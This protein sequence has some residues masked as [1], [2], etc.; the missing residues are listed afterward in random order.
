LET[1]A[2]PSGNSGEPAGGPRPEYT[3]VQ[4]IIYR[5]EKRRGAPGEEN[6]QRAHLRALVSR[7]SAVGTLIE[8]FLGHF[9]VARASSAPRRT[10][11]FVGRL[12]EM[13]KLL[14]ARRP[15]PSAANNPSALSHPNAP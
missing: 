1:R 11:G 12:K 9:A 2:A 13:E 14:K 6:R 7:Q 15:A 5:L 4:T 3:T 8:D 10:A